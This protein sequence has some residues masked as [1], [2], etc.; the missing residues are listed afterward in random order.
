MLNLTNPV[1]L[2]VKDNPIFVSLPVAEIF[3]GF[4]VAVFVIEI[5]FTAEAVFANFIYSFPESSA[6]DFAFGN[7]IFCVELTYV[8]VIVKIVPVAVVA[9]PVC[10]VAGSFPIYAIFLLCAYCIYYRYD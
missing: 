4:P 3:G 10:T 7:L 8:S 1:P 5:S 9:I 2:V 6:I